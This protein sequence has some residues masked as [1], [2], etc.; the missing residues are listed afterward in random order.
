MN[1]LSLFLCA[2]ENKIMDYSGRDGRHSL[3]GTA[4]G[5]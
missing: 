1:C 5:E 3:P 4:A 2:Y